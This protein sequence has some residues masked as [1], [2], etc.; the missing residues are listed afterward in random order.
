MYL[1]RLELSGFKSFAEK[2]VLNFPGG[3]TA[4]VGPN[5]SGKSNIIDAVRWL[6][7]E[8]EAKNM[9]GGRA[10]DLIFAGTANRPKMSLAQATIVFDNRS[11]FFPVDFEEVAIR[12]RISRDGISEYFLNDAEVRAKDI[13]D[14]FAKARLG[15]KGFAIIN[16]G[17]SDMFVR[18]SAKE[19]REM[20]E[21]MLGLRQ[22]Q[23]KKHDAELK[24]KNTRINMEKA[25]ALMDE[26][27]P[28]LKLLR[29]QTVKWAKYDEL[30]Q[31][32]KS[33]EEKYFSIKLRELGREY[34]KIEP[35]LLA[36]EKEIEE[37]KK[38]LSV[39]EDAIR[40]LEQGTPKKDTH[41]IETEA[42]RKTL[43]AREAALQKEL[44]KLEAR[45]EFAVSENASPHD[46]GEVVQLLEEA[47]Q[48]I[49]DVLREQDIDT[50]YT[51][52]EALFEK[53]NHLLDGESK[54]N[55]PRIVSEDI[56]ASKA[57]IL[58]ELHEI[59]EHLKQVNLRER[60]AT[61]ALAGFNEKFKEAVQTAQ[62]KREK[63]ALIE[64][65]RQRS[66]FDRER[67]DMRRKELAHQASQIGRALGEFEGVGV[68]DENFNVAEGERRMLRLRGELASIGEVDQAVVKEAEETEAR[69]TFLTHQL[70]DLEQAYKD[71]QN[72]IRELDQ[73]I[74][75]GFKEALKQI[76]GAF[77]EYFRMMFGGGQAKLTLEKTTSDKQPGETGGEENGNPEKLEDEDTSH[78]FDHGGIEI[79]ISIPRKRIGSLDALSGGEKALVSIA[80]LFALISVSPP[81]FLVLDEVDA[82]LDEAN[83][84]RFANLVK[85]F[86]KK[87]QFLVVTHNRASMEAADILYGVTM[88]DDGTSKVLSLKLE[89]A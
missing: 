24:L 73:K 76:N 81:P 61:D 18:A 11:H 19:R 26:I 1:K 8:R 10:E 69:H 5:G 87:T 56:A 66:M 3:I 34:A 2:T 54:Q 35:D 84:K 32:L 7:G 37:Q 80:A 50:I 38:E 30:V 60:T 64:E 25:R 49:E 68:T 51:L 29:R 14:F 52:L 27:G 88:G 9:R 44:G 53:I 20:L 75:I 85:D 28:H 63:L 77:H 40:K 83:T 39:S 58:A 82:P 22:F 67:I 70:T 74:H 72:L 46:A 71:L 21:E 89:G 15:T 23:I 33:L 78:E 16:Q 45:L 62:K 17:S 12:R 59:E 4:V 47:R 48:T 55:N 57:R 65:R 13:I 86:A 43:M 31:E 79:S 42:E 41:F 36:I 6:L